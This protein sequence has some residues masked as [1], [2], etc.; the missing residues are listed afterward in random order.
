MYLKIN[1]TLS[2]LKEMKISKDNINIGNEM[3]CYNVIIKR[4]AR[5]ISNPVC[6]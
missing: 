4:I 1:K 2:R 6:L 5:N 3:R